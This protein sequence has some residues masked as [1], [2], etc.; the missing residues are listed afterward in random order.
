MVAIFILTACSDDFLDRYPVTSLNEGNFYKTDQE[1]ILLA[2]GCY[3]P[4]KNFYMQGGG[5]WAITELHSDNTSIQEHADEGYFRSTGVIDCFLV[6]AGTGSY[7]NFWNA[8]YNGIY[9]CNKLLEEIDRPGVEWSKESYKERCAGEALFLRALNYFDLVRQFGGVPLVLKTI[10]SSEAMEIKR[11]PIDEVYA[12]IIKD[13]EEAIS[14]FSKATDVEENGRANLGASQTLLGKV[15]LTL[16]EYDKAQ[17]V[18]KE[19]INSGKYSLLPNYADLFDPSNKDYKETIFAM[20][21]SEASSETANHFIFIFAPGASKG[22]VTQ[23]PS[24]DITFSGFN[25]P[26]QDLIDAFEPGDLRKDVS[27]G[28]WTGKDWDG[29]TK[30]IPYCNKYKPPISAPDNRCSDNFPI[31]RYAD[32]Y[33]MYAEVLNDQ[34]K[35]NEAISYVQQVRNRA[36]LTEPLTEFNQASLDALIAHERQV[37]FCFENQ[38]WYDLVRTG[39]AIE[40]MTAHGAREKI[41]R[42]WY[43]A[44]SFEINENKLLAPIPLLQ[45]TVNK[46]DQNPGY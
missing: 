9:R 6:E 24:V 35:T 45:V 11:S 40:V 16:H 29:I 43:P 1:Y 27:I 33:L 37:E 23:R 10:T 36:G 20:Q 41:L 26:T 15:Y 18:L 39:K 14:H 34:G 8:A 46:L 28:F 12:R 17:T 25:Q 38:R 2:N 30:T 4:M 42:P 5:M 32:V 13:L 7:A 22:E 31:L 3:V 21:Y 19:V 44:N